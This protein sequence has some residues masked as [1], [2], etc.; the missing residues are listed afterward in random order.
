MSQGRLNAIAWSEGMFLRPHHLQHHDLFSEA[1]LNHHLRAID[2][3]HW[4]VRSFEIDED[5][6]SD[7]RVVVLQLDAVLPGGQ[8]VR[9]PN[10]NATVQAREFDAGIQDLGLHVGIRNLRPTEPN[11]ARSDE[12]ATEVRMLVRTEELPDLNR[13]GFTAPVE[14]GD[15]NVRLFFD[16]EEEEIEL[17]E[18]VRLGKV[19][20][21]GELST[22][23]GLSP[24]S[25]PPLLALQAFPP[26]YDEVAKIVSQIA[27]KVRVVAGRTETVSTL[28]LPRMWMRYT[29]ARMTPVLRHLLSTGE[30]RP[31]DLYSALV[32]TAGALSAFRQA[33]AAEL[34][35]YRHDD[36][37]GCFH[38]LIAFLDTQLE[39]T[40]PVR[41]RELELGF[42]KERKHYATQELNT[43]TA[44]A[45]NSYFL[46]VKPPPNIE[47]EELVGL[48]QDQAKASSITGVKTLE[49]L[50]RAGLKL[51]RLPGAPTEIAARAGYEYFKIDTGG[52]QWKRVK[53]DFSFALSVGKLENAEMRLYVVLPES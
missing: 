2:P 33:E 24:S 25:A 29:L 8:V 47:V 46:G 21:T 15:W 14:V 42:D 19:V 27:A 3:F 30:T 40:L 10:G 16:G 39:E 53:E 4:G 22:P 12:D 11:S 37:S 7:G 6:L 5:A 28:D 34:P 9:Y 26:L 49:M 52:P 20:A 17:H 43:E 44:D 38:E 32:E 41:F 36:L 48:L 35:L 13:G 45:R 18:T 51:E 31:F 23:F 1:R 50:N